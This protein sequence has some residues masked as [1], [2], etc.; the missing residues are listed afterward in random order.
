MDQ[1]KEKL[2]I[3]MLERETTPFSADVAT[4]EVPVTE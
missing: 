3:L 1:Y 2:D 4:S